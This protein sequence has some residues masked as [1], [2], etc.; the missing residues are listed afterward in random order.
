MIGVIADSAEHEIVR[1]FFELFKTPWE[2]C[3]QGQRYE[4]LVC[5][6]GG[7]FDPAAKVVI[8]YAGRKIP[9]DNQQRLQPSSP[10]KHPCILQYAAGR[11]PV[12][13]DSIGFGESGT[14]LLVDEETGQSMA[15]L[16]RSEE[17]VVVRAGYDL[18]GE[19]GIL[20]TAGQPAAYAGMP[21]LELHIA[22]L[23]DAITGCGVSLAEIPPIPDGYSFIACLTHDVDHPSIRRHGWDHTTLGF[24]YRAVFGSLFDLVRGRMSVRDALT[25][26]VAAAKLPFVQLG[27]TRD[28]WRNFGD[29]YLEIEQGVPST[30]FIIPFQG[31]PGKRPEGSAPKFRAARYGAQDIADTMERLRAAGC[32]V[33]LHGIDAWIDSSKGREELD[34]IRRLT[35]DPEIGVRMHWLYYGQQSPGVLEKAGAVYDSTIGYNETVGYRAGTTQVYKPLEA[36]GTPR[37]TAARDGYRSV[38]P[39]SSR[40]IPEAG[41]DAYQPDHG[42]RSPVRRLPYGQLA[43]PQRGSREAVGR[44]LSRTGAGTKGPQSVVRNGESGDWVVSEAPIGQV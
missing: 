19:I 12:Y 43:R 25:N 29:R 5:A 27:L 36:Q 35:G 39:R 3:R 28:F 38:L 24:L 15:Y 8:L 34:E 13:G 9:F 40:L 26:W 17:R 16:H 2:F 21:A 11:L 30:F 20:L 37:I 42:P 6:G 31:R 32:E 18:F 7:E 10:R 41:A 4:V 44:L 23:R 33:A 22:F 1:E 14:S